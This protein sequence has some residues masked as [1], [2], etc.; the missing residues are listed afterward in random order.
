M[1]NKKQGKNNPMFGNHCNRGQ[2]PWNK[3][4][5]TLSYINKRR[6]YSR[7]CPECNKIIKYTTFKGMEKAESLKK[8]CMSCCK[9]GERNC[10]YK[11]KFSKETLKKMSENHADV[12]K[13]NN[14]MFNKKHSDSSRRLLRLKH[15][16]WI[17][18]NKN[19]GKSIFPFF[20]KE[21]CKIIDDYGKQN[22]Y[23]F[24]HALNGGEWFI[25]ELGYWVDGYDKDKN[26]VIEYYERKH[27]YTA[28]KD[29]KRINEIK[30]FLKC[31]I[32]I[33]REWIDNI[34]EI[35][36]KVDKYKLVLDK[37]FI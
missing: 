35:S 15:I 4:K 2:I 17:E 27:K 3:G 23:N 12:S 7:T 19:D 34:E 13:E 20:N 30:N 37:I 29:E 28:E 36:S 25:K 11:R 8:V 22:G 21:A 24:Q 1:K 9:K 26:V 6:L 18:K 5:K 14:P 16:E 10:N 32:I 31:K 33:I